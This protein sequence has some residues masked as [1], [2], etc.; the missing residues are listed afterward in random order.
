[1]VWAGSLR[2]QIL[3]DWQ[4]SGLLVSFLLKDHPSPPGISMSLRK[5]QHPSSPARHGYRTSVMTPLPRDCTGQVISCNLQVAAK[6]GLSVA[7]IPK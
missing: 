2:Y 1:M 4:Q 5:P 6:S 7:A 3:R